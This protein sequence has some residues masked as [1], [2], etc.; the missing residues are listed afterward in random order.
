MTYGAVTLYNGSMNHGHG[1]YLLLHLCMT[2][3]AGFCERLFGDEVI[4]LFMAEE[5]LRLCDR[6]MY[7]R[8][9]KLVAVAVNTVAQVFEPVAVQ[10][11][12]FVRT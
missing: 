11:Y 3:Q 7:P 5:A 4:L 2:F 8:S 1:V 9:Q 12:L 6:F 10:T